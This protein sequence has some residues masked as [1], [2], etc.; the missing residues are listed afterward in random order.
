MNKKQDCAFLFICQTFARALEIY[1]AE[2]ARQYAGKQ[3]VLRI[4][5]RTVLFMFGMVTFSRRLVRREGRKP[6]YPLKN[7]KEYRNAVREAVKKPI[8]V[9]HV[10]TYQ[11]RI[12]NYGPSSSPMGQLAAALNW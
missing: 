8:F 11:C 10:G 7:R 5:R 2:M 4:D 3:E 6:F 9:P 1:D 12:A